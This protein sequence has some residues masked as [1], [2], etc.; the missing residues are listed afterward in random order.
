LFTLFYLVLPG[1]SFVYTNEKKGNPNLI[2]F[3]NL[4]VTTQAG[5]GLTN[6]SPVTDFATLVTT[7]QQILMITKNIIILYVFTR[8]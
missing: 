2:D 4:S 3:F 6:I 5:V 1:D 8:I 7:L